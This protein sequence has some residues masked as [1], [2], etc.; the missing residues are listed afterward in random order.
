[1]NSDK[2]MHPGTCLQSPVDS[3]KKV[4]DTDSVLS[5]SESIRVEPQ[6]QLANARCSVR[7]RKEPHYLKDF[8][9]D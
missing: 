3:H 8:V 6:D 2:I 4:T 7:I 5:E 9:R 1:M